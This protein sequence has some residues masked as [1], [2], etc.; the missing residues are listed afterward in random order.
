MRIQDIKKSLNFLIHTPLHPQW[1]IRNDKHRFLL[2][3]GQTLS[4]RILD[5]GCSDKSSRSYLNGDVDYI[6]VDYYTADTLYHSLP[7]VYGNAEY[8]P[9]ADGSMNTVLLLDVLEHVQHPELCM[10]EIY[11]VLC[12]D[13]SLVLNLPF[14]YPLHDVPHDYQRWTIFGIRS[15][16]L[17][18]GFSI[19]SE[20][21]CGKALVTACL[22]VNLA[23]SNTMLNFLKRR[24]P[25]SLLILLMP[26]L[27]PAIN[28]TGF[29]SKL[30]FPKDEFMPYR[31][32][33][34]AM[35]SV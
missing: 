32:H 35:K 19:Q 22:M 33:L 14:I 24:H 26:I 8:L 1:L 25:G 4:G 21:S 6:G 17:D 18:K 20:H 28:L 7:D 29:L 13:G 5:I 31:Y 2:E 15:L 11:R 3:T 34:I 10:D 23:L 12:R 9:F 16:L 30:L 27:V